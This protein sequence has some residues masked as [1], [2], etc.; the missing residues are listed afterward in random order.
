MARGG[1]RIGAGRKKRTA[2]G[3]P[4]APPTSL[5]PVRPS[6]PAV[7]RARTPE[8]RARAAAFIDRY[9]DGLIEEVWTTGTLRDRIEVW[10]FIKGYDA[11]IPKPG[12]S[13]DDDAE[14]RAET[15]EKVMAE[16]ARER[17]A[18]QLVGAAAALATS[19]A[20]LVE[21]KSAVTVEVV[22]DA[23]EGAGKAGDEDWRGVRRREWRIA[24][25][26]A[27]LKEGQ[28]PRLA[29]GWECSGCWSEKS[30][31]SSGAWLG[32]KT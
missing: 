5:V 15:F 2:N 22:D 9:E 28:K 30:A 13:S 3:A 1:F 25:P 18:A 4:G 23:L 7:Q 11:A 10:R 20:G 24:V 6:A 8:A 12:G 26:G 32:P 21:R 16:V 14:R 17:S 19:A 31:F 29:S 27:V